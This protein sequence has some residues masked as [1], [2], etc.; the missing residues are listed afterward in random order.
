MFLL[1]SPGERISHASLSQC[2]LSFS[3]FSGDDENSLFPFGPLQGGLWTFNF[4]LYATARD[5]VMH[6][7]FL[8]EIRFVE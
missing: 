8:I 1:S 6:S 3:V 4:P 7:T 5:K 2:F